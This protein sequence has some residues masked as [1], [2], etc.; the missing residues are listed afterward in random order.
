MNDRC[1]GGDEMSYDEYTK[2]GGAKEEAQKFDAFIRLDDDG[3]EAML[4][5]DVSRNDQSK[6][7]RESILRA[8][9]R[10]LMPAR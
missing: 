10:M 7:D 2:R 8:R 1:I 6:K 4:I 3:R 9:Q 5:A